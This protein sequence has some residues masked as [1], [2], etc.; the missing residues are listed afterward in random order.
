MS[1]L[2]PC[3][4]QT[5][6]DAFMDQELPAAR[7]GWLTKHL[8]D[9]EDCRKYLSEHADF[10]ERLRDVLS[11]RLPDDLRARLLE[12]CEQTRHESRSR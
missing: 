3:P 4:D 6:L 11:S 9:C 2:T 1:M 5:E 8:T 12:K 10:I 7:A